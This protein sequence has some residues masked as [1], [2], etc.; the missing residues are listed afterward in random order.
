VAA[1]DLQNKMIYIRLYNDPNS[2]YREELKNI[3][4]YITDR[5]LGRLLTVDER[6][7]MYVDS[8]LHEQLHP[9]IRS[10]PTY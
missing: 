7:E 2:N 4:K 3:K 5:M 1:I 8:I 6:Y 9:S 10:N